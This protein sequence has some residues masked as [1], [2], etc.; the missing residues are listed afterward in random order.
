M[1]MSFIGSESPGIRRVVIRWHGWIYYQFTLGP[2]MFLSIQALAG[3]W[4]SKPI[5]AGTLLGIMTPAITAVLQTMRDFFIWWDPPP[6]ATGSTVFV[7]GRASSLREGRARR[8]VLA[9]TEEAVVF[10]RRDFS[11]HCTEIFMRLKDIAHVDCGG[12]FGSHLLLTRHDGSAWKIQAPRAGKWKI[13][14]EQHLGRR[15]CVGR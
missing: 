1:G 11:G 7:V 2:V 13:A 3:E 15:G 9:I 5:V 12:F 6:I 4:S 14:V 10:H 8:G